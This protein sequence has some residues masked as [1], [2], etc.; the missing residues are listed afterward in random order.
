[1]MSRITS[2]LH[3]YAA[4]GLHKIWAD[5]MNQSLEARAVLSCNG[6]AAPLR[7]QGVM[8]PCGTRCDTDG[9][10]WQLTAEIA[11]S[12]FGFTCCPCDAATDVYAVSGL[13]KQGAI[14]GYIARHAKKN[15]EHCGA[16]KK[17]IERTTKSL[18]N[19]THFR[20][21]SSSCDAD[22]GS[23]P[24]FSPASFPLASFFP[25]GDHLRNRNASTWVLKV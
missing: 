12:K 1:M 5:C 18:F 9:R 22:L 17:Q 25:L 7:A 16:T 3:A 15:T 6:T 24:A 21:P 23:I 2:R 13:E 19:N 10:G 14:H 20:F 11:V 8:S 4:R